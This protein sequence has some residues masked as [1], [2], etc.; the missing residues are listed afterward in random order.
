MT[1]PTYPHESLADLPGVAFPALRQMILTQA[2]NAK[3]KVLEDAP[4]CL[5][6]ETA[7][8]LIG[9]RPGTSAET[10]GMVAATDERWL[11][12][13]K[14]AVVQQMRMAMPE[15]A[16]VMR[17]SDGDAEGSLPANFQFMRVLAVE[18]LG[19]VFLRVTLEGEDLSAHG[20]ASIHFRLV[21]PPKDAEPEW[22]SVAANGSIKWPDGPGAP[23]KPVYTTRSLDHASRTL[24]TDVF[25]HEGGRTTEW[26]REAQRGERGRNVVGLVGP[27]GGGILD[28]DNVLMATDE[29]GFPAAARLLENLPDSATG[30]LLLESEHGE[31]CGYP[32]EAPSGIRLHWLARARGDRL[33]DAAMEAM[34]AHPDAHVWFA[35]EKQDARQLR[36]AAKA[37]GREPGKLRISGFWSGPARDA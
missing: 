20:D 24:V 6:V 35:G 18:D 27:S 19:P 37:A 14:N 21:Q 9:L 11:F 1:H 10:A 2:T 3:L 8:G 31:E 26:A 16:E 17:W 32:F 4:G 7:H 28:A 23:H 12:V 25:I 33:L 34:P 22:P 30:D 36:D 15:V 5:T 13:M 29:T